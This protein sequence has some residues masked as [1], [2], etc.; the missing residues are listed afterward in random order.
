MNSSRALFDPYYRAGHA[1]DF[2]HVLPGF[3][4]GEG[5]GQ[6]MPVRSTVATRSGYLLTKGI[7]TG[8][9]FRGERIV[10]REVSGGAGCAEKKS[11]NFP[12]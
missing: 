4:E 3:C 12:K 2:A 9:N 5:I 8:F 6:A 1:L 11:G 10:G 7:G